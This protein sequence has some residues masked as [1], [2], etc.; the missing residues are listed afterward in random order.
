M[1]TIT[2]NIRT[3]FEVAIPVFACLAAVFWFYASSVPGGSAPMA[4]L[5]QNLSLQARYNSWA[6]AAA[7]IAALLQFFTSFMPMCRVFG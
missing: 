3:A 4:K 6:A 5:E 2:C 7:G 1:M